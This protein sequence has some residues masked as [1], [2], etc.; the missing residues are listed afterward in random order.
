MGARQRSWGRRQ[1][2]RCSHPGGFA[3]CQSDHR[4][5]RLDN[6][7]NS[8]L[9]TKGALVRVGQTSVLKLLEVAGP[10]GH[11]MIA[12]HGCTSMNKLPMT[13]AGHLALE[14]E[15]TH[16]IRAERPRLIQRIQEAIADEQEEV[17]SRRQTR[18]DE[19]VNRL[20]ACSAIFSVIGRIRPRRQAEHYPC[21][22]VEPPELAARR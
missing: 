13:T 9:R 8:Y 12:P 2:R 11:A 5:S 22:G 6:S 18:G 7:G 1:S 4:K 16:R 10:T 19:R 14:N 17:R 20:S 3:V 15:L 21:V